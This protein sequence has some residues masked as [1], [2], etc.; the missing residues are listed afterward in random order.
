MGF[1]RRL[2]NRTPGP[3]PKAALPPAPSR[4][5]CY[6]QASDVGQGRGDNQ[7]ACLA[8]VS[9]QEGA[10]R[11]PN[12]GLF[13][14][15][16]GMGGYQ[17]GEKASLLAARVIAQQIADRTYLPMLAQYGQ[18]QR[19]ALI[20]ALNDAIQQA[21][22]AVSEQ[23]PDGGT[24]LT[25]VA[26]YGDLAYLA[27]V[28]DSRAYLMTDGRIEQITR[29]HSLVQRLVELEQIT[30]AQA[31]D[32]PYRNVLYRAIGQAEYVELDNTIIQLPP[33]SKLLLCSDGLWT[34]V[35][36]SAMLEIIVTSSGPQDACERLVDTANANGGSD[37]ITAVLVQLPG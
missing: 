2:F 15:A 14:V 28:G 32:H 9:N 6:G 30:P 7:D 23:V 36:T 4:R 31:A 13:V 37:N 25:A 16:D 11:Q 10:A 19:P 34:V 33:A 18:N 1:L 26:I 3:G 22:T 35:P 12:F 27:H 21:N 20:E 24:T 17:D 5:L 29:D 8:I